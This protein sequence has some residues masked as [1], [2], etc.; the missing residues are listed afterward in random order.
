MTV[1]RASPALRVR[2][3]LGRLPRFVRLGREWSGLKWRSSYGAGTSSAPS[4]LANLPDIAGVVPGPAE[5]KNLQSVAPLYL[6]HRFD[7]LGSGWVSWNAPGDWRVPINRANRR[8]SGRVRKLLSA[9][10]RPLDW[11]L[12]PLSGYRFDA[13]RWARLIGPAPRAGVEIK[14]PWELARMQH[15]PQLALLA[16]DERVDE[17][18]RRSCARE[19]RD[20]IVDFIAANPP[21]HGVNWRVPMDIAIRAANWVLALAL[22]DASEP[23]SQAEFGATLEASLRDHARAIIA[24][25]EW[26][27]VGRG[28]HY[29]ANICGLTFIAS[30]LDSDAESNA[31]LAF[32]AGELRAEVLRQVHPDGSGFEAS[33]AYHRLSLDMMVAA[34]ALLLGLPVERLRA[35]ADADP[36]RLALPPGLRPAPLPPLADGALCFGA[37][38]TQ[39]LWRARIFSRDL[40]RPDGRAVLIGDN[41]S[42]RFFKPCPE[43]EWMTAAEW[44]SRFRDGTETAPESPADACPHERGESHGHL[45]DALGALFGEEPSGIDGQLVRALTHGRALARPMPGDAARLATDVRMGDV[46]TGATEGPADE[47]LTLD[48][49]LPDGLLEQAPELGLYPGWGLYVLRNDRF[50]LTLRCG[51]LGL[52]GTGNHDHNDQLAITLNVDGRDLIGDPGTYSYTA[53]PEARDAYRSVRA[54]FAPRPREAGPEPG[55]LEHGPWRL[56][57]EARARMEQVS[58]TC[59]QGLHHGFGV[60]VHRRIDIGPDLIRISDWSDGELE[61]IPPAELFGRLDE[62]GCLLPYCPDYGRRHRPA[63]GAGNG[64]GPER[65]ASD[66]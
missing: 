54:H 6:A 39:R 22:L 55:S 4:R 43:L 24:H 40:A 12:D 15:L 9:D 3:F 57:D 61:L 59:L 30:A 33:S 63:S 13:A 7:L 60:P 14:R 27:P 36:G 1:R 31:W 5:L 46:G 21:R 25:L 2:R 64:P 34:T 42:G 66:A 26:S 23:A 62:D 56:G 49:P 47:A 17:A 38:F 32:A 19:I 37:D 8:R 50:L 45:L 20:E 53:Y 41:D 29:L 65:G 51:P 52:D 44:S 58:A 11:H 35:L 18:L 16:R 48:I 28:N 10:Y